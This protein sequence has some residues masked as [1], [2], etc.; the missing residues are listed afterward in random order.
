MVQN[1][2]YLQR[3]AARQPGGASYIPPDQPYL[4]NVSWQSKTP[5]SPVA[6]LADLN[7]V[8]SSP[9]ETQAQVLG[10]NAPLRVGYG[11]HPLGAQVA[12]VLT[13]NSNLVMLLVWEEGPIEQIVSV[14]VNGETPPAGIVFTHYLGAAGQAADPTMVSAFAA[15]GIT[16]VDT[17]PGIA[18]TVALIPPNVTSGWPN[19]VAVIQGHLLYDPRLDST[20]GGTGAHRANDN[21]TWTYSNCPALA[22]GDFEASTLYGQGR[23]VNAASRSAAADFNDELVGTEKRRVIGLVIDTVNTCD[24]WQEALRTYAGCFVSQEGAECVLV[25][26]KPGSVE[27]SFTAANVQ[28][29]TQ[30]KKRGVRQV[31]TV[32]EVRYTDTSV[33][34]WAEKTATAYAPGVESGATPRRVSR[35]SLP[36]VTRYS[37]AMREAIERLNKLMLSDLYLEFDAFDEC[38]LLRMGAIVDIT[39][40]RGLTAKQLRV[41]DIKATRP[42]RWSIAALEYDPAGYS[43]VVT[44]A[45]TYADTALPDPAAPPAVTGLAMA[46]EVF[47]LGN[48]TYSSRFRVTFDAVTY[49]YIEYYRAELRAGDTLIHTSRLDAAEWATPAIQEGVIYTAKVAV[50]SSVAGIVGAWA[51]QSATAQG[52]QL[53]PGDVP[54]VSAFEAGG[55]VYGSIE[56]AVDID[57]WR[58]EWKYGPVGGTY[59]AAT[60]LDLVDGLRYQTAIIPPGTW[61]VHVKAVDSIRQR[62]AAAA[63]CS[64]TVTLDANAF[65]ISTYDQTNPTVANMAEY[66]LAPTN[67]ARYWVTDDG[68]PWDIKFAAAMGTYTEP[69]ATYHDPVTATW[70]GEAEDFGLLLSGS[71]TGNADTTVLNGAP[72]SHIELSDTTAVWNTSP[73]TAAKGTARFARLLHQSAGADTLCVIAGTQQVSL[74]AIPRSELCPVATPAT[75]SATGPVTITLAHAYVKATNVAVTLLGTTAASYKVNNIIVGAT[76]SFEVYVFDVAGNKIVCPFLW[77]FDGVY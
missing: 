7:A 10:E 16:Y 76:T 29:I 49:P 55:T 13:W 17:L 50:V 4:P 48:G 39:H 27:F 2:L 77:Q 61:T 8:A 44:A 19:F 32:M 66:H 52:K 75:S 60:L 53:L 74:S 38:L 33:W 1:A 63:S 64:V 23:T 41:M 14:K 6:S 69:L 62:S 12:T 25:P 40:P 71:W 47:Q 65:L 51:T 35:V 67:P 26:D 34:P 24:M 73:T 45:P 54:S 70:T 5:S 72:T 58:Y 68:V 20:A 11:E 56:P 22:L 42:G 31:P 36:G 59:D 9:Q 46:E 30:M 3:L 57:I 15:Q 37:Q 21:T 43:N 28:K 18:Y